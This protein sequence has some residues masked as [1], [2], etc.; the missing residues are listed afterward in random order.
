VADV[1]V[2]AWAAEVANRATAPRR[3]KNNRLRI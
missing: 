2:P 3:D 1:S